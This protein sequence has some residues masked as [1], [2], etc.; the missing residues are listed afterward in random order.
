MENALTSFV[1][2]FDSKRETWQIWAVQTILDFFQDF[3]YFIYYVYSRF[4]L[5]QRSPQNLKD[6]LNWV[7]E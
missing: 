4:T 2:P 7:K 3:I 5:E 1:V 6:F